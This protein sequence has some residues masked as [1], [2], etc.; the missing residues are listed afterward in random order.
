MAWREIIGQEFAKRLLQG[1][2]A[3]A[4]VAP[5]YL[6][7]GPEGVGKRR[8]ALELAK[9]L[10][11]EAPRQQ[12]AERSP[13][14]ARLPQANESRDE[15][16]GD[17]RPCDACP[18]CRQIQ[19]AV[20]PDVHVVTPE[21][22]SNQ[23]KIDQIRH[24]LG[25]VALRPFSAAMQAAIIDGADRLTEEA[26]N[27][28]LKVLEAPPAHTRF[29]LL[30]AQPAHCLPTIV[31]RCQ[32]VRCRPL[33]RALV[34]EILLRDA[35]GDPQAARTA[36]RLSG[37]SASQAMALA[38]RWSAHEAVV[39]RLASEG[40]SRWIEEPMPESRDDVARFLDGMVGWLRDVAISAVGEP[41][42]AAYQEHAGSLRR[43]SQAVRADR[44]VEAAFKIMALRDSLEQFVS[45]RLVASLARET[46]L[47]L[48]EVKS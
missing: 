13:E 18:S 48:R 44:C 12:A 5:A 6:L 1:H 8:L 29:V 22:A 30:S 25:R 7:V 43:Q 38:K 20:H 15:A 36:A 37:G 2:L 10:N 28:L 23:I 21:G 41:A 40:P 24:L 45:P 31:S 16:P 3:G 27:S 46:W 26:A 4:R 34:E 47:S 39:S 14:R 9:A 19:R 32:T 42:W 33:P 11:C 17:T 35:P